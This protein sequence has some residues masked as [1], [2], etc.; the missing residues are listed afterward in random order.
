VTALAAIALAAVSAGAA[1]PDAIRAGAI[2]ITGDALPDAV[3]A[4][5]DPYDIVAVGELH[6]T[7]EAPDFAG[8]L[9]ALAQRRGR[10]ALLALEMEAA[11]QDAVDRYLAGGDVLILRSLPF[12]AAPADSQD[13][14]RSIAMARLLET[15]RTLRVPVLCFDAGGSGA[16]ERD[17]GMAAALDAGRRRSG[18]SLVVALMGNVH[19]AQAVGAAWDPAYRPAALELAA[20]PGAPRTLSVLHRYAAGDAWT[21]EG[22]GCGVHPASASKD[23]PFAAPSLPASYFLTHE[24]GPRWPDSG[25]R[26]T[27][28]TRRVHAS[29]PFAAAPL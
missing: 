11:A 27:F 12:F 4:A 21:C 29:R 8:R 24:P 14:R 19:S 9:L 18:A 6:G 20:R 23:D 17:R 13:G 7:K 22:D 2:P 25:Y 5:L 1:T 10:S 16:Q 28:F 26:A 15:A 3:G